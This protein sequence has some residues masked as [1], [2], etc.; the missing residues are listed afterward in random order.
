MTDRQRVLC[1]DD[2]PITLRLVTRLLERMGL[3]VT[4]ASSPAD[5]LSLFDAGRF[6]LIVT[7]IRMPGM[8]GHAFLAAVRTRDPQIPVIVA[9]GHASLDNAI[10]AL[11]DGAS[12]MLIKPFTG[13]EFTTEVT[14][15]LQRARLRH[16]ALQYRFVTPILDGV[17]LAL[18]AAI[19]ARDLETGA[20]CMQ[21]GSMGE[22]V[23]R[24]MGLSEQERTTIRIGGYLHDVGKIAIADRI[25][26]KPG[27]LTEEEYLEMQRHAAIGAAIVQTHEAM[28]EI[29]RIVHHHHERFDG[30][31]YPD[32]LAGNEIPLGA[33][34]ISV[35]DAFS[36]MTN[37]RVY[38][39]AIGAEAAWDEIRRNAGSQF[40]PEIVELFGA[41]VAMDRL[42]VTPPPESSPDGDANART[43]SL[44]RAAGGQRG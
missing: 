23:A 44:P 17:A 16:E 29:A 21:L 18:T 13:E 2:E 42:R 7:D 33:R 28:T 37:D 14:N 22:Q 32:R 26:L 6:D 40:D 10:R 9:T 12:G 31:G 19:E 5:A 30:R 4:T 36:A 3:V 34:I 1:V 35:A 15:A 25:L 27:P 41:A 39:R 38:R 43:D 8:D 24:L 20:H 11:R